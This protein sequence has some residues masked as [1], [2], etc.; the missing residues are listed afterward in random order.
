MY[1]VSER[2]NSITK[3][4]NLK[5]TLILFEKS[6]SKNFNSINVITPSLTPI[7]AGDISDNIPML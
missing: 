1:A 6:K 7:P 3:L 5:R 2:N 4:N